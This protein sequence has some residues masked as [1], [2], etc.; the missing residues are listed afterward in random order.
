[1][2]TL[3]SMDDVLGIVELARRDAGPDADL[4]AWVEQKLADR[5]QARADRD[6]ARADAIRDE[7]TA[8]GVVVEDTPQGARWKLAGGAAAGA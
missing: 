8:A 3:H 1:V 4:A 7:L 2:D 6:F 5:Q